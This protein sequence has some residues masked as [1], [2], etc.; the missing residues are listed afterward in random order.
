MK[1]LSL[2][3]CDDS[4]L[5]NEFVAHSPQGSV[6]CDT[7]L[8]DAHG[9]DYDLWLLRKGSVPALGVVITKR[10]GRPTGPLLFSYYQGPLFGAHVETLPHYRQSRW[11]LDLF[12]VCLNELS[13]RYNLLHF[14]LHHS[15]SDVRAF[16][17]FN[18]HNPEKGRFAI[19]PRYTAL[20]D[21]A[22]FNSFEAFMRSVRKDR[23][24]DR[25][26]ALENGVTVDDSRDVDLLVDL[27]E[28]TFA[29]Q[30]LPIEKNELHLL[31]T[32][33]EATLCNGLGRLLMARTKDGTAIAAQ[34][35]LQ[36]RRCGHAVAAASHPEHRDLGGGTLVCLE[37]IR[38]CLDN[39]LD[40]VDFNGA[41]SPDR[42]EFKHSFGARP[43][44]YFDVRWRRQGAKDDLFAARKV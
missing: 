5:W 24:Q 19:T 35:F 39:K 30:G 22:A 4:A 31:A 26:V 2:G 41:N 34:L 1:G 36:D 25:R 29:R 17:W 15:V 37:F 20:I 23:R 33:A 10:H 3:L 32:L 11:M 6:F 21:L 16:D 28:M 40:W 27:Y 38:H 43:Q 12:E 18:Y 9:V 7:R 8:L 14:V 13:A 44:L 42:A